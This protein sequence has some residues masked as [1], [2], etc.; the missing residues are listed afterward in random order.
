VQVRSRGAAGEVLDV[1]IRVRDQEISFRRA[2]RD[3]SV[4]DA[5][6]LVAG[7]EL[8]GDGVRDPIVLVK[9]DI[10]LA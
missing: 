9:G 3:E 4:G 1:E 6:N 5:L 2:A 8:I 10:E 7:I